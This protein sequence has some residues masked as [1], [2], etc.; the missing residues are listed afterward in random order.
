[1]KTETQLTATT[2][3]STKKASDYH[4]ISAADYATVEDKIERKHSQ[5]N[6]ENEE[7]RK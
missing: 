6:L 4:K 5:I 2:G 1:L 3:R 7:E